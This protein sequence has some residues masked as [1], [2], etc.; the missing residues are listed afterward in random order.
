MLPSEKQLTSQ[1]GQQVLHFGALLKTLRYRYGL[2]QLDVLAQLSGWTQTAYSRLESGELAPAFDQLPA[3]YFALHRAGVA[4]T[5]QD[6]RQFVTLAHERIEAKRS[7][8][9]H[10]TEREW[11]ELRLTLARVESKTD[12]QDLTSLSKPFP[13]SSF[14]RETRHLIG[15]EDW[16][17]SVLALLD[18]TLPKKLVV[19]QG[20]VGVGKS[21]ELHR[22]AEHLLRVEAPQTRV[23]LCDLPITEHDVELESMLDIFLATIL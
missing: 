5:P 9:E 19:L 23:V 17:R 3:L 10:R 11:D 16:L 13:S 22:L 2:K 8:Q 7:H 20:P 15:R 4:F 1:V 21:S 12:E 14:L 18:E 6:R